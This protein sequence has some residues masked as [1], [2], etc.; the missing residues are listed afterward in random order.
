MW[1]RN[2]NKLLGTT[3]TFLVDTLVFCVSSD[4]V[5]DDQMFVFVLKTELCKRCLR[6]TRQEVLNATINC[7]IVL[8]QRSS[9]MNRDS[10]IWHISYEE[11]NPT[12]QE[13]SKSTER[14]QKDQV[15]LVYTILKTSQLADKAHK[16]GT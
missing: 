13:A 6:Q 2:M 8:Y 9:S 15:Y 14:E 7:F 11:S 1:L 4:Y 10:T 3:Y 16:Q 12:L 5:S